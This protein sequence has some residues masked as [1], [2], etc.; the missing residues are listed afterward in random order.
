[1]NDRLHNV[2]NKRTLALM[3]SLLVWNTATAEP[4]KETNGLSDFLLGTDVNESSWMKRMGLSVGGWL[5]SG[6]TYNAS[7]PQDK[8][9][10]PVTFNDR[11][12][13]L[14]L[15][16]LYLYLQ[17]AVVTNGEHWDIG[18]RFDFMYGTDS[19]FT[20]ALG[21]P[22]VDPRTGQPL[23][24]GH[25]DQHLTSF[26]DRFYGIALPQAYAELNVP[27]GNGLNIKAG[28]FY[29]PIGYEVVPAPDN[30]FVSKSYAFQFGPFTHT[31]ILGSYNIDNNWNVMAGAI[32]GS[33]TGGWDGTWDQQLG[34]W[35]F[36][37][38]GTWTSDDKNYALTLTS[39]AGGRSEQFGDAWAMYSLVG[40]ANFMDNI[41]HY[42]IQH[43]HGFAD[44]VQTANFTSNGGKLENAQWYGI[45]QY[46]AYDLREDVTL[47]LRAEWWRD[48]NG[49]RVFGPPRCS[50]SVNIGANGNA[51]SYACG[52]DLN[53][54]PFQGS[55]YYAIT[56][57]LV[58]RPLKWV[59]VRPNVRYDWADNIKIFDTGQRS[60][61]FL[62]STD[63]VLKF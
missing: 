38:G 1:M 54:Y 4:I 9:N 19:I 11:D 40:K 42:I 45:N 17:R 55:S 61:Q 25:W 34:N 37:G 7:H 43:D 41:L 21:I 39:T 5:N 56:A 22:Y 53:A 26:N 52:S 31:G 35:D 57:G 3:Y 36:L 2:L 60:D 44:N 12:S 46:L 47:G 15:N 59:Q 13:E 50:G 48:N 20:Q 51:S 28:H 29:T 33:A 62:F 24:R 30:F 6:V 49:F 32:T 23:N 14:Q 8:F 58:W 10:G 16:Q 27:I 63:L 18:G